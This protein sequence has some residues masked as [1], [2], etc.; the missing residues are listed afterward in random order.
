MREIDYRIAAGF[1][2]RYLIQANYASQL[3]FA[4]DFGV[5][6]RTVSRY[7]TKGIRDIVLIQEIADFF[8]MNLLDYLQL[9]KNIA[10]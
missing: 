8:G 2:L 9:A 6:L 1:A 4:D 7:V 5:D 10:E 3:E